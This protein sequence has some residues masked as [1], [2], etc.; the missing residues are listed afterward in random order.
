MDD[1][2]IDMLDNATKKRRLKTNITFITLLRNKA[3]VFA[4]LT[5]CLGT[6]NIQFFASWLENDVASHGM[7]DANTGYIIAS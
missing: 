4:M 1:H 6:F 5:C 7:D 2:E 3:V